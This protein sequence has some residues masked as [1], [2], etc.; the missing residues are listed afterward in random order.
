MRDQLT[1]VRHQSA[2]RL[3]SDA[4][5]TG[6]EPSSLSLTERVPETK[7]PMKVQYDV[8]PRTDGPVRKDGLRKEL[9]PCE[10]KL[11]CTVLRGKGFVRNWTTR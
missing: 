10:W 11:S 9:E 8:Q 2:R 3:L 7:T 6:N 5:G 1:L 4:A